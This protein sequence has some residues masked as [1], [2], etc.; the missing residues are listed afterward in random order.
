[1]ILVKAGVAILKLEKIKFKTEVIIR[2]KES[3]YIIIKVSIHQE[4]ITILTL[5]VSD[6]IV[7]SL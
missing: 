3:H 4:N 1:M 2:G 5:Y 6:N 7:S